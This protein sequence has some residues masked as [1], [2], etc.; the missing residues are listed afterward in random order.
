MP[1]I[2][3]LRRIFRIADA[4]LR[5]SAAEIEDELRFHIE[6][7]VDDLMARGV[8]G[9]DAREIA[10]RD[11][12][13]WARYRAD[14]LAIDHQYARDIRM[15]EFVE[16]VASDL[17]HAWTS[18][19]REPGFTCVAIVTLAL[20]I[21]ATTSVFS[22]VSGV[23][24]RPLPYVSA[25]RIVHVGERNA[26][27]RGR[28]GTT[29][30]DNFVDWMRLN[31]SFDA[32]GLYNTW[33][34]TLTGRGDPER[35]PVAGVSA[36]MFAVF[37]VKPVLGRP[38]VATD[39]L[40]NSAAVAVVSYEFWRSHLG[41]DPA[42]VGQP[43]MLNFAPVQIVGV[44]PQGFSPPGS[45]ARAVWTNFSNDT[46][47]RAG[48]SKNVY[49]LLKPGVTPEQ[50][51]AEMTRIAGQLAAAYPKEN[52]GSTVVVDRLADRI[53][54][55]L[56]R[57]LYMLF[58]AS[59]LVLL[60]ACANL[61]N[62]LLARGVTR[63][64][65][66][67]VR[68]ALGA[69]RTRLVR[70]LLTESLVLAVLGSIT[71][72]L[73]AWAATRSLVALGPEIFQT[74]PPSM[75]LGV[76]TGAIALAVATT[77]LFGL[78]PAFR[79]APRDP[80]AILRSTSDRATGGHTARTRT[81][82]AVVQLSLAVVLLSASAMLI[83][84][85]A[86]VLRI[87]PGIRADHVL[88]MAVNLP[89]ARYDSSKSTVFYQQLEQRLESLPDVRGV[90]F[91]SLIPFSGD[92]DRIGISTISGEPEHSGS[93]APEADRYIVSP[94]YFKTMGVRLVRGR[95]FTPDDR[96]DGPIVCLVD[97]V[98]SR[99]TWG[100]RN[101]IGKQMRLPMRAELATIVGV[102]THV[103][104]YGLDAESPGQVYMSNAQYPYRWSSMV[105]RTVGDPAAFAPTAAR[106]IHELDRDEPVAN[107]RTMDE[108]MGNLLRS[109]RF[110]LTLLGAFAAVAITLAT[111]GL[112]G[113]IAY[114]VS[115][116]RREFGIRV[117]LGARGGQI[118]RLV[119]GEGGRI[120]LAGAILGIL[121][122]VAT[123]RFIASLLFDVSPRDASVLALVCVGLV[124]VAM[125]AC[126]VPARRAT[127]VDAAEVLRGD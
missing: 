82:L 126:L 127:R 66:L 92:F 81:V 36:G 112:Y 103:K 68:A 58:G 20:G 105:V 122:A 15:R 53:I 86:H 77:L 98:F 80:Q 100:D 23:L 60:I 90:A 43:L 63:R 64:R 96:Y 34:P 94:G 48:R 125:L 42:A 79:G 13:D 7:R 28:G 3:G 14:V 16:S 91:T 95:L 27:E 19:G 56:R 69:A 59:L 65:E 44:M 87:E 93:D 40:N 8:A 123:S 24:L 12:G 35:V 73:I 120:A 67:A 54:G 109:R 41:A 108:L 119:V 25:D 9:A 33:Q 104:T 124:G 51:Q 6:C 55:D 76:L 84:S 49:A 102:V 31:R 116:R 107:V 78:L 26:L 61:S 62:L 39:N 114:G 1:R 30:Y 18:F 113:V 17:R 121:G 117:A 45:L 110:M 72:I 57:P 97:E 52:K 75:D 10:A 11:F 37:Q 22:A 2:P 38:F 71:G 74:R 29:S 4:R 89:R 111:V 47:G 99:R 46:D 88:T 5:A 32:M 50:A 101:P 21:G 115:Q 106:V 70:Q 83:K 85:F 118:A